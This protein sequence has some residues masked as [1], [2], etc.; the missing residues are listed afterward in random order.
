[1]PTMLRRM[2]ERPE[3]VLREDSGRWKAV[4]KSQRSDVREMPRIQHL[5]KLG[6]TEIKNKK[7]E[8]R[9]GQT[10]SSTGRANKRRIYTY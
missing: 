3:S 7:G 6:K 4:G 8:T 1:M 5:F 9:N 2:G 10:E